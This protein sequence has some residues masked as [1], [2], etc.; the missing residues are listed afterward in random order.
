MKTYELTYIVSPN[1]TIE[2]AEAKSKEIESFVSE[3]NG[4]IAK[5]EKPV[6]K[7]LSYRIKKMSSGFFVF[8]DFQIEPEKIAEL[9]TEIEKDPYIIRHIIT[10]KH[11]SKK[12]AKVR[13]GKKFIASEITQEQQLKT[14]KKEPSI[15]EKL[16]EKIRK[17]KPE[18]VELNDIDKQ[19]DEILSE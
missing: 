19:L 6:A 12:I 17:P 16:V 3:N 8:L 7:T 2:E 15:M 4:V 10:T 11:I 14:D 9:K 1:I 5:S 18:K 13:K